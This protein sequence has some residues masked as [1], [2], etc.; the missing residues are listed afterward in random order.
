MD[1]R[2]ALLTPNPMLPNHVVAINPELCVACNQCADICR[3]SVIM[4]NPNKD[5]PPILV[6]PDECWHCAVCTEHCPT[7]AITFEHPINQKI[8]F[9]DKDSGELYRVGMKNPPPAHTKRAY[10]DERIMLAGHEVVTLEATEVE[11][12]TRYFI[13]AK[14]SKIDHMPDYLPGHFVN[15]KIDQ[16]SYRGYSIGN[17]PGDD[18]IELYIDLFPNGKGGN[19]FKALKVGKKVEFTMP[20]GRF[21]YIPKATPVFF[22]GSGT[23]ISSIKAM[24]EHEL[25]QIKSGRQIKLLLITWDE[26]DILLKEYFDDLEDKF[27][28]FSYDIM[29]SNQKTKTIKEGKIVTENLENYI[30]QND[31]IASDIDAY[32]CGSK[33]LVKNVE[34]YLFRKNMFWKNIKYESF[35]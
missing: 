35:L 2:R 12:L 33:L 25:Y 8:V 5:E 24:I 10:G 19:F 15:L 21:L 31:F 3:C 7:G 9:K 4:H 11:Q 30:K 6:Y 20:L 18:F 22:V 32:I 1:N 23:G 26:E 28:N 13:K 14:F 27:V 17:M 29:L 34:K 16:E